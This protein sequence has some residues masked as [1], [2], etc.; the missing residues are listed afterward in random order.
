MTPLKDALGSTIALADSSGTLQTEY[1][2]EPFGKT[3]TSGTANSNTQKYTG[4]EDDGTGL[5]Y[6]RNRYYS[7][8]TQRFIS[9]DPIGLLCGAMDLYA[10]VGD[11]PISGVDPLGLEGDENLG[12]GWTA[13]IDRFNG[14]QG[15]EIHVFDKS[16]AE[17]G[18]VSGRYG[19]IG[20][21]GF[22]DNTIPNGIPSEV[23]EKLNGY[24][25]EQL[26]LRAMVGPKG[27]TRGGRYLFSGRVLLCAGLQAV[28]LATFALD[29]YQ[30]QKELGGRA[31]QN[32]LTPEEQFYL[33]SERAGHPDF[34]M[35][36][37]GITPNP[38]RGGRN[39]PF[40]KRI[41]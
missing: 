17:A 18:I 34:Y 36:P 29:E 10:Y 20:K 4:R 1:I 33:D 8:T 5:Y 31:S 25:V 27:T 13:R 15:F 30:A 11:N 2:Y 21:H 7:P 12:L 23:L 16:G 26:R 19:W 24:N 28:S 3:T 39:D 40:N 9:E 6:Y 14:G 41:Y 37:L 35:S 32:G 22:P 38:H